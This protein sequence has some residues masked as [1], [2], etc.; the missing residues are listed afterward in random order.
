MDKVNYI[1]KNRHKITRITFLKN[2]YEYYRG[3]IWYRNK[4]ELYNP[5]ILIVMDDSIYELSKQNDT[6]FNHEWYNEILMLIEDEL[7]IPITEFTDDMF[8]YINGEICEENY[9]NDIKIRVI[10]V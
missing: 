4:L 5:S 8:Y 9:D 7:D 6:L 3:K 10:G 2:N 1:I